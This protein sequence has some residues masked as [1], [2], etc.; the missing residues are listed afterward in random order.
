MYAHA[1]ENINFE[2]ELKSIKNEVSAKNKELAKCF[3]I[4]NEQNTTIKKLTEVVF[5]PF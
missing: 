1:E 4:I 3:D 2:N 5:F